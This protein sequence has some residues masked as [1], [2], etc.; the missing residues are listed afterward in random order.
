MVSGDI[1]RKLQRSPCHCNEAWCKA[2]LESG[3]SPLVSTDTCAKAFLRFPEEKAQVLNW[4]KACTRFVTDDDMQREADRI[5]SMKKSS[6][7]RLYAHHF[8]PS[9]WEYR[10]GK[11]AR[12]KASWVLRDDARGVAT[13][14]SI[15]PRP[16]MQSTIRVL[17]EGLCVGIVWRN[18]FVS[19]SARLPRYFHHHQHPRSYRVLML[20]HLFLFEVIWRQRRRRMN[21]LPR[22]ILYLRGRI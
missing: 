22:A 21:V 13:K 6:R 15:A 17:E 12:D 8:L 7:P 11:R 14:R 1:R 2:A 9:A 3:Q 18:H 5:I 10:A 4:L 19:V 16:S 20:Y